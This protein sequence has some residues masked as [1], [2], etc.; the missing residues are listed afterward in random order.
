VRAQDEIMSILARNAGLLVAALAL[1]T[2]CSNADDS[3]SNQAAGSSPSNMPSFGGVAPYASGVAMGGAA[4][5]TDM[6]FEAGGVPN[7]RPQ[8]TIGGAPH[9]SANSVLGGAPTANGGAPTTNGGAP[10]AN[11]GASAPAT[12]SGTATGGGSTGLA[13]TS[14]SSAAAYR[15]EGDGKTTLVFVN[16]C[17]KPVNY[18]GSDIPGGTIAAGA[19]TSVDIGTATQALSSKRYWGWVGADP[20]AERHSL[21]EFTFNT[22]FYAMDWYNISYVDAFNL[23]LAILPAA[24][25]KCRQLICPQDFLAA[26]PVVGQYRDADGNLSSCVSPNRDDPNSPV[27]LL[28][29]QCDDAYAWSGD[30]Q[31]GTDKS[32]MVGCEVEDFDIVFCPETP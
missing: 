24:R 27:P 9:A 3:V 32:P 23:P 20:G 15:K 5:A 2:A 14:S 19:L 21:A 4:T 22:D 30:D 8:S 13:G 12:A 10:T 7:A 29:E 6:R 17:T 1:V 25:P 16:Q 18:R 26:C 11:G 31:K 28:F